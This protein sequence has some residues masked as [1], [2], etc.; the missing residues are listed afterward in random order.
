MSLTGIA[1]RTVG[2]YR[3][4]VSARDPEGTVVKAS[5]LVT[6]YDTAIQNTGF[7]HKAFHVE[8]V[9]VRSEP[10]EKAVLLL[11]SALP[12]A[13]VLMEVERQGEIVV[14]RWFTLRKG[15]QWVELPVMEA[16]RG[17]FAV[18]FVCVERGIAHT[19][20]QPIDVPWSNKDLQVEWMSFRD[21][22]LPGAKEEWRLKIT[23][24]KKERVAAQLL[25][26]LYD[27]SLDHF[28]PHG[29]DMDLWTDNPVERSWGRSE[30]FGLGEQQI[31]W[32]PYEKAT[33]VTRTYPELDDRWHG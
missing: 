21:K 10:G 24:P 7:V 25:S 16:D 26:V 27:A 28:V 1:D 11:S 17:G 5:K 31:V 8:A 18:H 4:E 12:E 13:R 19:L 9:K 20:T 32:R 3:I 22:L 2:L 15:Q 30:P 33:I 6:L 14:S 23:G 29:W